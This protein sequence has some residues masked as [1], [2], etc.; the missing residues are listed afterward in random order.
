MT[1]GQKHV[2]EGSTKKQRDKWEGQYHRGLG[3]TLGKMSLIEKKTLS[4][5]KP[6]K[7][8][9]EEAKGDSQRP[10]G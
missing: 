1:K 7:K 3:E 9:S 6:Q 8:S 5:G 4:L 2:K 10:P